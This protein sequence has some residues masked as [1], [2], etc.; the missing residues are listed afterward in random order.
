[1]EHLCLHVDSPPAPTVAPRLVV[2]WSEPLRGR[3]PLGSILSNATKFSI[4]NCFPE[5]RPRMEMGQE[6]DRFGCVRGMPT[7]LQG[8]RRRTH[9]ATS[10]GRSIPKDL[11]LREG[12]N[13]RPLA[14]GAQVFTLLGEVVHPR[15]GIVSWRSFPPLPSGTAAARK[16]EEDEKKGSNVRTLRL[17]VRRVRRMTCHP[18]CHNWDTHRGWLLRASFSCGSLV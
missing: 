7:D 14:G 15:T 11:P 8:R 10:V 12:R 4:W 16:V 18:C 9:P 13:Q 1:M 17:C 2:K 3:G 5:G 6:R